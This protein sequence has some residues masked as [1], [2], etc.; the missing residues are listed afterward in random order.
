MQSFDPIEITS[1]I[2]TSAT[3]FMTVS[4]ELRVEVCGLPR[5]VRKRSDRR[6]GR[7]IDSF[8]VHRLLGLIVWH[9]KLIDAVSFIRASLVHGGGRHT[10]SRIHARLALVSKARLME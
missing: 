4:F 1:R 8:I 5:G 2:I 10:R 3:V 9:P 6:G 7:F